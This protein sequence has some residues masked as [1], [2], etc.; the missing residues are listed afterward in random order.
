MAA[1]YNKNNLDL[2]ITAY[3]SSYQ[4][5]F[6][7]G[8]QRYKQY[9]FSGKELTNLGFHYNYTFKNIYF[10]G[11]LA[12]SIPGGMAL[13]SGAM[14]SL[15]P[16]ISTVVVFRD[17]GKEHVTFYSK[18][19]GEGTAAANEKGIYSGIH[20]NI[21]RKW[22]A[23]VYG[24]VFWFPWAKYRIDAASAG[25]E[26]MGHLSFKPNKTFK[27]LLSWKTKHSEQNEDPGLPVNPLVD[28]RK[29]NYRLEVHWKAGRK[30]ELQNRLEIT[31]Y[32]K[33]LKNYEYGY[34][35]YQDADYHPM[36]SRFSGNLRLAYFHTTSYNSR[37]YAYEDDVLHG[38]G[39][40]VYSGEGIRT[41]LNLS[42]RLSKHLR[43][44][45]RYAVYLYPGKSGT[46]S[47]LDQIDGNKK[48]DIKFQM[49]YQ[50]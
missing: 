41:F 7:T 20:Y 43:A 1:T 10:F 23:S 5:E 30:I 18:G 4:H 33:G 2:G 34:L 14:A 11:E 25:Y 26:L 12:Q 15:S 13:L 46:G 37:I 19:M 50:F 49:R 6:M 8:N 17:Y 24:D 42:Y 29:D 28:L 16:R 39:S 36:S 31:S 40:G 47:G 32:K 9:S 38:S 44:W 22:T 45:C 27:A 35:I 21:S 3:H 48:S